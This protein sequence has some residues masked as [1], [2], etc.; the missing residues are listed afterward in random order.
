MRFERLVVVRLAR[1]TPDG[2]RWLCRCDCGN[3]IETKG[4]ALSS[5]HTKSCGCLAKEKLKSRLFTHGLTGHPLHQAW[6]SMRWRCL[7]S[8]CPYYPGYGGR[9]I[10]IDSAWINDCAAFVRWGIASGW[11]PGLQIDRK[12]NDGNYSP[13]NCR[14]VTPK[15]NSR[16]TR[17]TRLYSYKGE[18][19]PA[20][21]LFEKYAHPSLGRSGFYLR[22]IRGWSV[23]KALETPALQ[24]GRK[25][26]CLKQH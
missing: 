21:A 9:G 22:L 3:E 14:F 2:R 19:L 8:S 7:D 16:N 26:E 17:K 1:S 25:I 23:E 11:K 10:S 12:D 15:E 18:T 6:L 5:G 13:D 24:R 4:Y 20:I